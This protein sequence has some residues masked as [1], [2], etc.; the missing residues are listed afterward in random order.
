M[1]LLDIRDLHL[2]MRSFDGEAHVLNGIDLSV[3]RRQVWGLVGE[4]GCGKSLMA[5]LLPTILPPMSE[6]EILEVSSKVKST[7]GKVA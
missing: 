1:A 7:K 2:A 5:K 3:E 4:T 6:E